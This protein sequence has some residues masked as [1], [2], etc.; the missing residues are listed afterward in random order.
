MVEISFGLSTTICLKLTLTFASSI[1]RVPKAVYWNC[2]LY[3]KAWGN[4]TYK[5]IQGDFCSK[6][7]SLRDTAPVHPSCN[8]NIFPI[9]TF[10]YPNQ[11]IGNT[12][13]GGECVV[14]MELGSKDQQNID[15]INKLVKAIKKFKICKLAYTA[16]GMFNNN[17]VHRY[18]GTTLGL[19]GKWFD[20]AIKTW[21]EDYDRW[22][23][24][25]KYYSGYLTKLLILK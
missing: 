2:R 13:K 6:R 21:H 12:I 1:L 3:D 16:H 17:F 25:L 18:N 8:K 19:A 20:K 7:G 22:I 10:F 15:C 24:A 11:R 9:V 14:K 5:M 4:K 23:R